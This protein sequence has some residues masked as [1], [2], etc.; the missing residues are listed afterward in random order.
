MNRTRPCALRPLAL[1]VFA[2]IGLA[3]A[4]IVPKDFD[5]TVSYWDTAANTEAKKAAIQTSI[6]GLAQA[7]FEASNGAHRIGKVTVY[8]DAA[9]AD[10][11]DV[12]WRNDK[13]DDGNN[14]WFN[15]HVG[16]RGK[17]GQRIQHCDVGAGDKTAYDMLGNKKLAGG[18]ILA[19]EWGHFFYALYDE[20]AGTSDCKP[21]DPSGPCKADIA[22]E[23]SIMNNTWAATDANDNLVNPTVLNFSTS[24]NNNANTNAQFRSYGASCWDTITRPTDQDPASQRWRTFFPEL[25]AAK[26]A[27]G[28]DPTNELSTPEGIAASM[29]GLSIEFK[30][31]AAAPGT[32]LALRNGFASVGNTFATVSGQ[33]PPTRLFTV[34]I[35][36]ATSDA[37]LARI[38]NALIEDVGRSEKGVILGLATVDSDAKVVLAPAAMDGASNSKALKDAI[39]ALKLSGKD[40]ALGDALGKLAAA[41]PGLK[42]NSQSSQSAYLFSNGFPGSGAT[43]AAGGT[44]IRKAGLNLFTFAG[45]G[46]DDSSVDALTALAED[47]GGEFYSAADNTSATESLQQADESSS[48]GLDNEILADTATAVTGSKEVPFFVDSSVGTLELSLEASADPSKLTVALV[49]PAGKST[50]ATCEAD[51]TGATGVQSLQCEASVATPAGGNWKLSI[52]NGGAAADLQYSIEGTPGSNLGAV[53]AE[54]RIEKGKTVGAPSIITAN[55]GGDFPITGIQ[56]SAQLI[57]PDGK[58]S[59]LTLLDDGKG[60]DKEENDGIYTGQFNPASEG[61]YR[62]IIKFDNSAGTGSFST[63]SISYVPYKGGGQPV[64]G[65]FKTNKTFVRTAKTH[66]VVK[67]AKT[68]FDRV[69]NFAEV[70]YKSIFPAPTT[71]FD[72]QNYKV[73]YYKDSNVYLA[74][75]TGDGNLYVYGPAQFGPNILKVGKVG[76]FLASAKAAGY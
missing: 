48:P 59:T 69:F 5:L 37:D 58:T 6:Q 54:A 60:S 56:V 46:T 11:A 26:P 43:L 20:Y 16:G 42:L 47:N 7:V 27:A 32:A 67:G 28:T 38:K 35:S 51:D 49:D 29:A 53:T 4:A 1:L 41:V 66:V 33:I 74:Y 12:V 75:N 23:G 3:Q 18:Y 57:A 64:K 19:H 31:G 22:V 13:G 17:A 24:K 65:L 62:A 14:C 70:A 21:N 45:A 9:F 55:V 50:A 68:D 61:D 72:Y 40:P 76:V 36:S 71:T 8:T 52:N 2:S 39:R 44:A 34:D 15:A 30:P 63:E 10:R 25:V 73:R